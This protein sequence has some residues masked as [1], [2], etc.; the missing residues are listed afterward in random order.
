MVILSDK[1]TDSPAEFEALQCP[2]CRRHTFVPL[3]IPPSWDKSG[4]AEI[5]APVWKR[6]VDELKSATRICVVGYSIPETDAFFKYLI[7]MALAGNHQ[8]YKLV[9]VD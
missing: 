7:T 5:I 4:Y 3:L 9:V 2:D 1:V 6:A 8:L